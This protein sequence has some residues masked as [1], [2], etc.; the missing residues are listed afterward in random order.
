MEEKGEYKNNMQPEMK[1]TLNQLALCRRWKN[2]NPTTLACHSAT[3]LNKDIRF[4][5]TSWNSDFV[6]TLSFLVLNYL[7]KTYSDYLH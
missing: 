7:K 5:S 3:S 6:A 2:K 4:E 1:K